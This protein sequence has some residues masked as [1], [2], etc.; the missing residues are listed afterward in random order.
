MLNVCEL[1]LIVG[2]ALF[3]FADSTELVP[4][5]TGNGLAEKVT[6]GSGFTTIV[7]VD[8]VAHW[9]ASGVNVYVVVAVLLITGL[10]AP[11]IALFDVVGKAAKVAPEQIGATCVNV[12]TVG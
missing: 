3:T 10:Q 2:V 12:G 6:I 8:V 11:V 5:Q 4:A 7:I 1:V 9:P